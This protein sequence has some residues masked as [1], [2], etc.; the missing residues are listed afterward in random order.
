MLRIPRDKGFSR[1]QSLACGLGCN[2]P[3]QVGAVLVADDDCN[4]PFLVLV[5]TVVRRQSFPLVP[6]IDGVST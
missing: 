4:D 6:A 5:R 1:Q 2:S 3:S